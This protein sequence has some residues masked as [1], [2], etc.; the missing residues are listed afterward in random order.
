MG[1]EKHIHKVARNIMGQFRIRPETY[2]TCSDAENIA[3]QIYASHSSTLRTGIYRLKW[4]PGM[5]G[6]LA[7]E[8]RGQSSFHPG[9][10]LYGVHKKD[11]LDQREGGGPMVR[12]IA[13]TALIA[14]MADLVWEDLQKMKAKPQASGNEDKINCAFCETTF[15]KFC[16]HC[17]KLGALLS[18]SAN[19]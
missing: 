19:P 12:E 3:Q 6:E 18:S 2:S 9:V 14:A 5:L 1:D 15:P 4:S 16:P 13:L 17:L 8:G 11:W 7:F 10:R